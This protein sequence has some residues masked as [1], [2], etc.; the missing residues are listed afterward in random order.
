M[1]RGSVRH[2]EINAQSEYVYVWGMM[3]GRGKCEICKVA[4]RSSWTYAEVDICKRCNVGVWPW[5]TYENV[6]ACE[7]GVT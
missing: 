3:K 2:S 7:K 1:Y 5:W 6:D 4:V